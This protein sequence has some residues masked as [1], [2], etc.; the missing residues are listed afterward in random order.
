VLDTWWRS[1]QSTQQ[2]TFPYCLYD[3]DLHAIQIHLKDS[4]KKITQSMCFFTPLSLLNVLSI[5]SVAVLLHRIQY[6]VKRFDTCKVCSA[7]Q[8]LYHYCKQIM[9]LLHNEC[10]YITVSY[11]KTEE[12]CLITL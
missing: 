3:R 10:P 1:V 2:Y 8:M 7:V 4:S 12:R 11:S 9:S 6:S 5:V